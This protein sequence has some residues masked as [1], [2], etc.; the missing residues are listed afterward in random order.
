MHS[1]TPLELATRWIVLG[2]L[3]AFGGIIV[4]EILTGRINTRYLLH[5][6]RKDGTYYLSPERI[7]LLIATLAVAFSYLGDAAASD[8]A[9]KLPDVP[10]SWLVGLG[11]SQV[12]YLGGKA[13]RLLRA[14]SR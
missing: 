6:L 14:P 11:G 3:A 1:L 13:L 5:G 10:A 2:G 12:I 4:S 9:G 7:Q 8:R